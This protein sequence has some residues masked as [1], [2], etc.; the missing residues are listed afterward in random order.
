MDSFLFRRITRMFVSIAVVVLTVEVCRQIP[1]INQTAVAL[2]LLLAV[3]LIAINA[4][5]AEAVVST[6]AAGAELIYMFVRLHGWSRGGGVEWAAI[7]TFMVV[8]MITIRLSDQARS[9][10]MEAAKRA[11]EMTLLYGLGQEF[12]YAENTVATIERGL[13]ATVRIFPIEGVAFCPFTSGEIFRAGRQASAVPEAKLRDMKRGAS[14]QLSRSADFFFFRVDGRDGPLGALGFC[15][16]S[17]SHEVLHM[18]SHRLAISL[19]RAIALERATEVEAA[20]R[21]AELGTTLLDS[22]AHDMKTPLATIKVA[23]ASLATIQHA[24]PET[25][26]PFLCIIDEEVNRLNLVMTEVL[27]MGRLENGLL[28][29]QR[30]PQNVEELVASTLEEMGNILGGR[31]IGVNI[32]QSVPP[33]HADLNLM[34]QVLKQLVDNAVKYTPEGTPLSISSSQ[35]NGMVMIEVADRGPGIP[36]E[37]RQYIFEKYYRGRNS[38]DRPVG[39]GLGLAIAKSIVSAHGGQIWVTA[40][41]GSGSVFHLAVPAMESQGHE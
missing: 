33:I 31:P 15:G 1:H 11:E 19:E 41:K 13:S 39:L 18:I 38:K 34:K 22:L 21:C 7:A 8:A 6:V 10:A 2:A 35:T 37:D 40:N 26:E 30:A 16:A 5:F 29:L 24:L 14:V 4:G 23:V 17:V 36:E 3:E 20:R 12:L 27:H 28:G 25:H 32:P 9:G